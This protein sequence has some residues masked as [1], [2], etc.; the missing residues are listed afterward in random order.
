[1]FTFEFVNHSLHSNLMHQN[2]TDFHSF[3]LN[4]FEFET[5][6]YKNSQFVCLKFSAKV[7]VC[8]FGQNL[9]MTKT[10]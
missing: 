8:D 1:M 9:K 3:T 4:E 6:F 7:R 2:L 10:S 5:D